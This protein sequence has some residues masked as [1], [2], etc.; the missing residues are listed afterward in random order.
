VADDRSQAERTRPGK[1][2]EEADGN[3]ADENEDLPKKMPAGERPSADAAE[4]RDE[5][6]LALLFRC[7]VFGKRWKKFQQTALLVGEMRRKI[8]VGQNL[9]QEQRARSVEL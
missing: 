8:V 4:K 3:A 6:R 7:G 2:R 5:G 9:L 1:I